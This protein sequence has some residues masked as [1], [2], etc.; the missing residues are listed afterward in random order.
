MIAT[1]PNAA[2]RTDPILRIKFEDGADKPLVPP[3]ELRIQAEL[4]LKLAT[5]LV[6]EL[7]LKKFR[8]HIAAVLKGLGIE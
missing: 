1:A 6:L 2:P 5:M 4:S 3:I 7:V 8:S